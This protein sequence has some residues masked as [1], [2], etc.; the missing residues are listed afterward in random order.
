MYLEISLPQALDSQQN[1]LVTTKLLGKTRVAD[2]AFENPD[3]SPV[4]IDRD[5]FGRK[6]NKFNPFAGPFERPGKE[7]LR[8]KI[9]QKNP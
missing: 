4:T 5:Y 9:W 6:R 8:L 3:G 7:K 1:K 2:T